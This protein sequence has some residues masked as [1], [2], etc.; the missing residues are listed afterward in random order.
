MIRIAFCQTNRL[1]ICWRERKRK[2]VSQRQMACS[3]QKWIST[4]TVPVNNC[5]NLDPPY[6][7]LPSTFKDIV[8]PKERGAK[9][10]TNQF[11]YTSHTIADDF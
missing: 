4:A 1:F 5:K 7:V 3:K 10:G 8:Q 9:R 2:Y 6:F 11:A